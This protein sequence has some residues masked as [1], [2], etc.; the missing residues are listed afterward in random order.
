M[1]VYFSNAEKLKKG[2]QII[3]EDL[4]LQITEDAEL[5]VQIEEENKKNTH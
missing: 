5:K 2:L 3:A 1:K 4:G